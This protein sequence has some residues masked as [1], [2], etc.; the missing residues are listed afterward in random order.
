MAGMKPAALR[1]KVAGLYAFLAVAHLALWGVAAVTLR[2]YPV[3]LGTA[4]LAYSFGLRHALDAD[5]IAAIDNVTRKLMQQGKRPAGVGFYFSL[6]HST[7]VFALSAAV[8]AGAVVVKARFGA[9]AS[10]GAIAGTLV[11]AFFLLVIAII[12]ALV[13]L[14][15]VRTFRRVRAGGRYEEEDLDLL[16][17]RRGFFGRVFR[18]LFRLI[19][20]SWQMYPVGLLFGLGFDTATEVGLLGVSAAE[21]SK[22]LPIWSIMVFPGLFAAGMALVDTTDSVLMLGA[23]GWAFAKPIR[24][25]YYNITITSVSVLLA[26]IV[27]GL[28]TLG[29]IQGELDLAGPFWAAIAVL[30]DNFGLLG[31]VIIGIFAASWVVS[32]LVYR[33][34]RYDDIEV[35]AV[36]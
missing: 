12:N 26:V 36:E 17:G 3:L 30:N 23:Y 7:V 6:G 32:A 1:G 31:Y 13:L 24:K 34:R 4:F 19:G 22:G 15:I 10:F 18:R 9:L 5:H 11:S 28:E 33:V 21:A 16:L 14:A 25:L 2:A 35:R 8:A 27:G 20:H 29:L